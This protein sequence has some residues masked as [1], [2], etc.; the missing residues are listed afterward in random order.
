[1][2]L[3]KPKMLATSALLWTLAA[4]APQVFAE[5][6]PPI[7]TQAPGY[8]R[9]AV[10]DYEVT[11][12]FDGYNDL[13][14]DLLLNIG[15]AKIRELLAQQAIKSPNVQTSF[16][17]FLINTGDHLILVDT[18]AGRCIGG[19][20]GNLLANMHAAGYAP[21]QIDTIF[22]THMHLDHVCGLVGSD[23]KAL[24]PKALVYAS[25]GEADYWLDEAREA[26]LPEKAREGF[27]IAQHSLAPYRAEGR[28]KTFVPP[29]SPLPEVQIQ[30]VPGH[31]PGSAAYS[32][33]SKGQRIVFI[34]DLI[35]NAAVQFSHPE[36][37]I[38][39]DSDP[40]EAVSSR[41][42]EFAKLAKDGS[43]VAAA[44]LP[45]PGVGHITTEGKNFHWVPAAYGPY[46]R[47]DNVPLLK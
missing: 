41:E 33:T 44:H 4:I 20:A 11:A 10:G 14:S 13:S 18:G 9:L 12:L 35:H 24:F 31:T 2:S 38:K 1:M 30:S 6:T 43:W 42:S 25:K 39:F 21:E 32:F 19:T 3:P 40:K 29:A 36:V 37:A 28:L 27:E 23:G 5:P 22:L 45:F 34:G 46:H 16:N 15:Q 17:A 7:G 47:P 26:K 8:F